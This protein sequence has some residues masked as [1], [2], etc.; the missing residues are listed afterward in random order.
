MDVLWIEDGTGNIF[1]QGVCD[2]EIL[3]SLLVLLTYIVFGALRGRKHIPRALLSFLLHNCETFKR[4]SVIL[5]PPE[6]LWKN[7]GG[8]EHKRCAMDS[9]R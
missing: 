2:I 8:K 4:C 9:L 5:G 1:R 3:L 7:D 6:N